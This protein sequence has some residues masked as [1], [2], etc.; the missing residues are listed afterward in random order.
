[1]TYAKRIED[2]KIREIDRGNRDARPQAPAASAPVPAPHPAPTQSASS[3]TVGGQCQSRFYTLPSHQEQEGSLDVIGAGYYHCFVEGFSFIASPMTRLT[4]KKVKFHW[5]DSNKKSFQ[6]LKTQLTLAPVLTLPDGR[7]G[8]MVYS[9]AFRVGLGYVLRELNLRQRRW[10]ELVKDFDMSML[11]HMG[12][13]N[14]VADALSRLS[15]GSIAHVE[16]GKKELARDVQYLARLGVRLLDLAEGSTLRLMAESQGTWY[17]I[18]PSTT[19]MYLDLWE[20]Y[21]WNG[22]KKDIA[23]LVAKCATCEKVKV[24]HQRPDGVIPAEEV[25]SKTG[26]NAVDERTEVS[27]AP[28][29]SSE[30][31]TESSEASPAVEASSDERTKST[32][33]E[34]LGDQES[35]DDPL[36]LRCHSKNFRLLDAYQMRRLRVILIITL[37]ELVSEVQVTQTKPDETLEESGE[38]HRLRRISRKPLVLVSSFGGSNINLST[39]KD[40]KYRS[41]SKRME[42]D[43]CKERGGVNELETFYAEYLGF[44]LLQRWQVLQTCSQLCDGYFFREFTFSGEFVKGEDI[45]FLGLFGK[46]FCY[47]LRDVSYFAMEKV[48]LIRE[49]LKTA[50]SPQKSYADVRRRYLEFEVC[51]LVYLKISTMKWVKSNS[52]K[53]KL[54]PHYVGPYRVLSPV[55]KVANELELP[56]EFSAVHL[57]F[58]VSLLKKHIGDS[59]IVDPLEIADVKNSLSFDEIPIE[60]LD[61]QICRQRKKEVP[62]VKVLRKNQSV[63]GAS[64]EAKV[65]MRSKYPR[66]FYASSN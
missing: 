20:I 22:M 33:D 64:W 51:D 43:V 14:I 24:E 17:S 29:G 6:E 4:Q 2:D 7:D 18:H 36:R 5:L 19:K 15:M 1:M 54:I 37:S 44:R 57:I 38:A 52:K 12:K 13:A 50:Q 9:Y 59:I 48:K 41:E 32:E 8:F 40:N 49:R 28:E 10:L 27:P 16:E 45:V 47:I 63:E 34:T 42:M 30:A 60:I 62:L 25:I 56:A 11:H 35:A 55:G 31:V 53:G 26:E 58:H 23:E 39:W 46:T 21:W 61:F 66:L 3:S 65:D